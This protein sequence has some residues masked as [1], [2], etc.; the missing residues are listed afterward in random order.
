MRSGIIEGVLTELGVTSGVGV[1]V[2][3]D[4]VVDLGVWAD[5]GIGSGTADGDGLLAG[6]AAVVGGAGS[7]TFPGEDVDVSH[8]ASVSEASKDNNRLER[9]NFTTQIWYQSIV[10]LRHFIHESDPSP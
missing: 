6:L 5:E 8:A 2:A 9:S 4:A 7:V 1:I 3:T 10:L